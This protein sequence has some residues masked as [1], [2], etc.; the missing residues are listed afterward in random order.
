MSSIGAQH[1][2]NVTVK[3]EI[4]PKTWP[5]VRLLSA[6]EWRQFSSLQASGGCLSWKRL[7]GSYF[8][9]GNCIISP[10]CDSWFVPPVLRTSSGKLFRSRKPVPTS[11]ALSSAGEERCSAQHQRAK[12]SKPASLQP[13]LSPGAGESH[14]KIHSGVAVKSSYLIPWLPLL[15]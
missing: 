15:P 8:F 5:V 10:R 12:A 7:K 6:W 11:L 14:L 4:S 9:S 1:F 2:H 13:L 3:W